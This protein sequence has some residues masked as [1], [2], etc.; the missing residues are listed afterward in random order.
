VIVVGSLDS[1]PL[2]SKVRTEASRSE[3][4]IYKQAE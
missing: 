1:S 3:I 2:E 4:E